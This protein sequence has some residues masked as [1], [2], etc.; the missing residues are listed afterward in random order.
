MILNKQINEQCNML[1]WNE[2]NQES[3]NLKC[4]AFHYDED[5]AQAS[6]EP[7]GMPLHGDITT[8]LRQAVNHFCSLTVISKSHRLLF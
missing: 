7:W 1:R 2:W 8:A 5:K 3:D 6:L 4:Y